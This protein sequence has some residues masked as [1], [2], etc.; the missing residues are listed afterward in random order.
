MSKEKKH[1]GFENEHRRAAMQTMQW[2][3]RM[4]P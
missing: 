2:R 4:G 1:T 3:E